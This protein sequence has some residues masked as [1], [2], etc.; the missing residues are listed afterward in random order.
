M[1]G[2]PKLT[3]NVEIIEA[4][5]PEGEEEI[6]ADIAEGLSIRKL[7]AKLGL[8]GTR[9][10]YM[11]RNRSDARRHAW[12]E[13]LKYRAESH[14]DDILT[15]ADEVEEEPDAIAKANLR[16]NARKW[17]AAVSD[18][19]RFSKQSQHKV[20]V[21]VGSLHLT[22]VKNV[23][24]EMQKLAIERQKA[25]AGARAVQGSDITDAEWEEARA[26]TDA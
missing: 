13:A 3:A 8:C 19:E 7:A 26:D 21:N 1:P 4:L 24:A 17:L 11:W 15:I 12:A 16:I 10:L 23:N 5:G 20:V 22:A 2:H 18:P 6:F 9:P 25:A 14:A